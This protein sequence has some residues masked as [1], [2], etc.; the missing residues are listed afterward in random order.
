[1]AELRFET[2]LNWPE[3]LSPTARSQQRNDHGFPAQLGLNEAINYLQEELG[4]ER[5]LHATLSLDIEQPTVERLRKKIG[6]R[7]G[8]CLQFK[9][10]AKKYVLAC[11]RWQAAEQNIY[12]LS[13]TLRHWRNMERWGT[14]SLAALMNGFEASHTTLSGESALADRDYTGWMLA[15][16]LGPT[17]TLDDATAIYHRRAKLVSHDNAELMKLNVLMDEARQYFSE[18]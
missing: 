12:A 13:L 6:N 1:M 16:G 11:D 5:F 2:P 18:K 14:G 10:A 17:A 7:S 8:A 3:G 4:D 9:Y 15:F